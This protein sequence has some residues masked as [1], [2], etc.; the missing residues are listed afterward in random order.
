MRATAWTDTAPLDLTGADLGATTGSFHWVASTDINYR[1]ALGGYPSGGQTNQKDNVAVG[2]SY[3]LNYYPGLEDEYSPG[4]TPPAIR[5][6]DIGAADSTSDAGS[7]GRRSSDTHDSAV[8]VDF[9]RMIY[10]QSYTV[11]RVPLLSP[12]DWFTAISTELA[13]TGPPGDGNEA[14]SFLEVEWTPPETMDLVFTGITDADRLSGSIKVYGWLGLNGFAPPAF[15]WNTDPTDAGWIL[16]ATPATGTAG[17]DGGDTLSLTLA[18]LGT[19]S[20]THA[21]APA[22]WFLFEGQDGFVDPSIAGSDTDPD[23]LH[24]YQLAWSAIEATGHWDAPRYRWV[25]GEFSDDGPARTVG[26][27]LALWSRDETD[28]WL[29]T[30]HPGTP[31][32]E[33]SRIAWPFG[34]D[35][36][37]APPTG[38]V[39]FTR[40][41]GRQS[42]LVRLLLVGTEDPDAPPTS[43]P[44][45]PDPPPTV[46]D[47]P[48]VIASSLSVTSAYQPTHSP[49][50]QDLLYVAARTS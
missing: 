49:S 13:P 29:S 31:A 1:V 45:T 42:T 35:T 38:V 12:D 47:P 46:V 23:D 9:R 5:Q 39:A 2:A 18:G 34:D 41:E 25:G 4:P 3:E 16:L 30:M 24:V 19:V 8:L 10:A 36:V 14:Y 22:L 37:G 44:V 33:L 20:P 6:V 32:V 43:P 11:L 17:V 26:T 28:Y 27:Y 40:P 7:A 50:I 48:P 15:D 21:D